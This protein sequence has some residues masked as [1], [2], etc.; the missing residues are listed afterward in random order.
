MDK[1]NVQDGFTDTVHISGLNEQSQRSA[2][3][4]R[5]HFLHIFIPIWV[6]L[7]G[8]SG[9][10]F[11]KGKVTPIQS[12]SVSHLIKPTIRP[13]QFFLSLAVP[14]STATVAGGELYVSGR[15]LPNTPVILYSDTDAASVD[16]DGQGQ[17][18]STIQVGEGGGVV[19][20]VAYAQ[21]GDEKSETITLTPNPTNTNVLG[22]SDSAPGLLKR[23]FS[24]DSALVV[25]ETPKHT[26][27]AAEFVPLGQLNV[28][29]QADVKDID[30][31]SFLQNRLYRPTV[32]KIGVLKMKGI[33]AHESSKS[34]GFAYGLAL[35]KMNI[36]TSTS[37]ASLSRHAIMGVITSIANG[38]ITIAHPIQ[39]DRVSTILYNAS[40]VFSV[41]G[42]AHTTALDVAE[43][44]RI[45]VIGIPSNDGLLAVRIHVVPGKTKEIIIRPPNATSGGSLL[46]SP[47]FVVPSAGT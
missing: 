30:A 22:K 12:P 25:T 18:E 4:E 36:R 23:I 28:H 8:I 31:K 46:P 19:R 20:V 41:K 6:V 47:K 42:V 33:L 32:S 37:G 16:S 13:Q 45:V 43:G 14:S 21:N 9:Y 29:M 34:G 7:L 38:V 5:K 10:F 39:Q 44:M 26:A 1:V 40:T 17:F 35:E 2:N 11:Y 27:P 15:T 3:E 24:N